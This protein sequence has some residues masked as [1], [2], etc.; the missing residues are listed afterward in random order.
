MTKEHPHNHAYLLE[1]VIHDLKLKGIRIT[2]QRQ[3]ILA[4]MVNS[5]RHPNVQ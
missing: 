5:Q 3:A 1:Q 2:P 4:Y